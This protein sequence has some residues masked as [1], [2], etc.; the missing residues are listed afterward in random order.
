MT[1]SAEEGRPQEGVAAAAEVG[2]GSGGA[3]LRRR[4]PGEG[5]GRGA[6]RGSRK[7][8]AAFMRSREFVLK[9][10][11][12]SR[13]NWRGVLEE[14]EKAEEV[15]ARIFEV[16]QGIPRKSGR[17]GWFS[18]GPPPPSTAA[19]RHRDGFKQGVPFGSCCV[20]SLACAAATYHTTLSL[21]GWARQELAA[22]NPPQAAELFDA[23]A[24]LCPFFIFQSFRD[25]PSIGWRVLAHRHTDTQTHR[26]TPTM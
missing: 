15:E 17:G 26:H 6:N 2:E 20:C 23:A 19:G 12:M 25:G 18:V 9:V 13:W 11:G 4:R 21:Q 10:R 22:T 1:T 8:G 3:A 5:R 7:S 24:K 14:L 16:R